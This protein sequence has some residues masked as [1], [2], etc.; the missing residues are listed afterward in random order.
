M[1]QRT[2]RMQQGFGGRVLAGL[3][4]GMGMIAPGVSGGVM[5]V[6]MGI[7]DR[8][9]EAVAHPTRNFKKKF[10]FLLPV[11][12][13]G[14]VG[15]LLLA[16]VIEWLMGVAPAQVQFACIGLVLGGVPAVYQQAAKRGVKG[17]YWIGFAVSLMAIVIMGLMETSIKPSFSGAAQGAGFLMNLIFGVLIGIG[18]VIPGV[19][20]SLLLLIFGGYQPLLKAMGS[21]TRFPALLVQGAGLGAALQS[22]EFSMLIPA[23]IGLL[24]S[25]LLLSKLVSFLLK[26]Y[27][28]YTYFAILGFVVGSMVAVFPGWPQDI[29]QWIISIVTMV[30]GTVLSWMLQKKLSTMHMG[31]DRA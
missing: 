27:Y 14:L 8:I 16:L 3:L 24:I 11:G 5:A 25:V 1:N 17:K 22:V 31:E 29:V 10:T 20:S 13:G 28:S 12:I 26:E 30:I 23:G 4:I 18:T 19:S 2:G 21:I 7:Y 6:L 9:I 15:V